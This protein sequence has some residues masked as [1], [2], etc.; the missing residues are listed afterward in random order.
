MEDYYN[1]SLPVKDFKSV[2]DSLEKQIEGEIISGFKCDGC[3]QEV[4]VQKRTLITETPNVLIV[5]L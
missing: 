3:Q 2:Q 4:E 1:L 5:H